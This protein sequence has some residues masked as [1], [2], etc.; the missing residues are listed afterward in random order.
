MSEGFDQLEGKWFSTGR[1]RRR[2]KVTHVTPVTS[3]GTVRLG[4]EVIDGQPFAYEPGQF[5]GIEAEQP[6]SGFRR[7][8]YCILSPPSPD[9][10]FELLVRVVEVG[11]LSVMLGAARPGDEFAFRGPT[12]RSM[13][14]RD[15]DID[16]ELL[17][18]GVGIAPMYSLVLHLL[19]GGW[20]R[21]IRL[22]WGLRLAD[23]VCLTD[24]LDALAA[25]Y[26]EFSYEISL[27]QPSPSWTGLRGRVTE[28]VPPRLERLGG[29][30]YYLVGNGAMLE[31]FSAALSDMGVH[32]NDVYKEPY[33]DGSHVPDP[34]VVA[35]IR[36]RFV[37]HDLEAVHRGAGRSDDAP[38]PGSVSDLF[39]H[40]PDILSGPVA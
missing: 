2:A 14:P 27:S 18:T 9:P 34:R 5:V 3:T 21:P 36:E 8:P 37:A 12:G 25:T 26:P 31:E 39:E 20:R 16:L 11:P 4:F 40:M 10:T 30:R 32:E 28:S 13:V 15:H 23:D 7:S 35:A 17:A 38:R 1:Y 29:R 6:G 24:E 19:A 33:F 22:W